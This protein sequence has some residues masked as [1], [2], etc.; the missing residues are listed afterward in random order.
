MREEFGA[1]AGK[2]KAEIP[3]QDPGK[4]KKRILLLLILLA[5]LIAGILVVTLPQ[6]YITRIETDGCQSI[7][8]DDLIRDSGLVTGEHLFRNLGGGIIPF[9]SLRYGNIEY[10]LLKEYPYADNITV[11]AVFPSTVRI[12]VV[13]RKKI[14]YIAVPDGY[15]VLDTDGYCVELV[16]GDPPGNVPIIEGLPVESAALG[17]K[18]VLS[19]SRELNSCITVLGAIVAADENN[20]EADSYSLMPN[21]LS[22]RSIKGSSIFL[23][24][25]LE[26]VSSKTLLIKLGSLKDISDAMTW[27]RY[28]ASKN[29]F[30]S[31]GDGYLDMS[32]EEYTFC[33]TGT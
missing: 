25:R 5:I 22:I 20:S 7:S 29:S 8:P 32:G 12:H 4:R 6:M 30:D 10:S 17:H 26:G 31:L 11:Q 23:T 1:V 18:A 16:S 19:E 28:A 9:F 3:A 13:E 33:P 15:A 2:R 27:L 21:V 14:G 24:I